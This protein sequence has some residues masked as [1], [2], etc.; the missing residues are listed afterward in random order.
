MMQGACLLPTLIELLLAVVPFV[1]FALLA[2]SGLELIAELGV[3][4]FHSASL[5]HGSGKKSN[6]HKLPV[7][8]PL[9]CQ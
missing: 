1:V 8:T 9:E 5:D 3:C 2:L 4:V 7:K 6:K